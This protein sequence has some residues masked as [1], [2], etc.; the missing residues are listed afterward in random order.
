MWRLEDGVTA[1]SLEIALVLGLDAAF[2][3]DDLD[4]DFGVDD[5]D[6]DFRVDDLDTDFGVDD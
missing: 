6:A 2:G 4:A 1:G 3:V 5:L